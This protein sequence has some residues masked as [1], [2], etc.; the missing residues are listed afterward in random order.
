[1]NIL[2][3]VAPP[4][5]TDIMNEFSGRVVTGHWVNPNGID[6]LDMQVSDAEYADLK[7][8][9]GVTVWGAWSDS[10]TRTETLSNISDLFTSGKGLNN[11]HRWFGQPD[12]Q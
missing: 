7:T 5:T 1:M 6:I 11:T 8:R 12:R 9:P 4:M 2:I 10:G 3:G